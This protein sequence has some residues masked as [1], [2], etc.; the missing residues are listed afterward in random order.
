MKIFP[1]DLNHPLVMDKKLQAIVRFVKWQVKSRIFRRAFVH[2]WVSGAK[3]Y[4]RNGETGLTQNIYVGLHEFYDM[5]FLLH[6]LRES[7][8]FIDVGANSGSYSILASS[9]I[10]ARTL[11]IEPIPSTY[12]RLVAN[13]ELNRIES[14]SQAINVGLGAVSG[15][16]YMTSQFDTRNQIILDDFSSISIK[17]QIK[18]LDEVASHVDPTL[19]KIDVEGWESEVLRG[20][21]KT[22]RN[23]SLLAIILELNESGKK[24]GYLDSEILLDLAE[25]GFQPISYDPFERSF[26]QLI[27]KNPLGGN[28]IFIRNVLEIRNRIQ[29][30]PE[31][32]ILGSWI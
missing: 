21:F 31:R 22:L 30:S 5:C 16:A 18:T 12:S 25:L 23:P 32:E 20:G 1:V 28:T 3:F 26:K 14:P 11:A 10:G 24:Y 27:G 29:N 6:L 15:S 9:I 17:V 13:F 4:V 8:T 2:N 19:I 7:D